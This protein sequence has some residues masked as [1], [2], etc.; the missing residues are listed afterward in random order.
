MDQLY[1]GCTLEKRKTTSVS[2]SKRPQ[3]GNPAR[4]LPDAD[5]QGHCNLPTQCKTVYGIGCVQQIL[6]RERQ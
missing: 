4:E 3:L 1:C 6:A 5:D 2:G